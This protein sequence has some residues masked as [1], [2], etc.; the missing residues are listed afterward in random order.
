M[1]TQFV[2]HA[3]LLQKDQIHHYAPSAPIC[4]APQDIAH[5]V[6]V[7][8]DS[9][10]HQRNWQVARDAVRPKCWFAETVRTDGLAR[11]QKRAR[12]ED[13]SCEPLEE[14]SVARCQSQIRSLSRVA[15]SGLLEHVVRGLEV[16]KECGLG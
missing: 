15:S 7:A 9:D 6:Q 1:A 3:L 14:R 8:V 4:V 16:A 12:K 13:R 10:S 11:T 2:A 5:K